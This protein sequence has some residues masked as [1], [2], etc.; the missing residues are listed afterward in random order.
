M[1]TNQMDVLVSQQSHVLTLLLNRPDKKNALTASMYLQLAQHIKQANSD[2]DIRAVIISGAGEAFTAGN[3]LEEF[4]KRSTD[5]PEDP[6]SSP[7]MQFI[8]ALAECSKP[9]IAA[10]NG[11]AVGIGVTLLLHCD[12]VYVAKSARFS[13]PFVRL[14]LVPEAGSSQIL[15][16]LVGQRR[17][18]E[19]LLLGETFDSKTAEDYGLINAVVNDQELMSYVIEKASLLA[20]L[21]AEAVSVTQQLLR[22]PAEGLQDRMRLELQ[23]FQRLLASEDAQEARQAFREKRKPVFN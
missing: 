23:Y 5:L 17:A 15:A 12:L 8:A 6:L 9:I 2:R 13:L 3:D 20:S 1:K 18:A 4:E 14:G 19:L 21:P 11:V 7:A 22:K 10:V 16:A